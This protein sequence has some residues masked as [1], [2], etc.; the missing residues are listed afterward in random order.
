MGLLSDAVAA[1]LHKAQW[2]RIKPET[3]PPAKF[4]EKV[5]TEIGH[6]LPD[7]YRRFLQTYPT[8]SGPVSAVYCP[9]ISG[10]GKGRNRPPL[11]EFSGY[12]ADSKTLMNMD[13]DYPKALLDGM[14]LIADDFFSNWFYLKLDDGTIWFLN[15]QGKG[16]K[17]F[18]NLALV[19]ESF[20]DFILRM[21]GLKPSG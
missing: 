11:M 20:D 14:L 4:I 8:R 10:P 6:P 19:G 18:K 1:K 3:V 13:S 15:R 7:E 21:E 12:D 16:A 17:Y 2:H 9:I 5:E